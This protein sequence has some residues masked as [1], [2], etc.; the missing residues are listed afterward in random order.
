MGLKMFARTYIYMTFTVF[1]NRKGE[2]QL[3]F[4]YPRSHKW[5][6]NGNSCPLWFYNCKMCWYCRNKL[7]IACFP[8]RRIVF[9]FFVSEA[10]LLFIVSGCSEYHGISLFITCSHYSSYFKTNIRKCVRSRAWNR[11]WRSLQTFR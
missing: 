8:R 11:F 1:M 7:V 9:V 6:P 5:L 2:S 4:S 10:L 3:C